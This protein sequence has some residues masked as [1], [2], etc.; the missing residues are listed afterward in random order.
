M[1][2]VAAGLF[3]GLS[4][5]APPGIRPTEDKV[6]QAVFNILGPAVGGCRFLDGFAGSG[7]LGIEALSRGAAFSAFIE[8]DTQ[9]VLAIRENL[10][11]LSPD[12]EAE[13]W[14]VL[15]LPAERGI[16]V[17][18]ESEDPFD[19]VLLDPPYASIDGKKALN[20]L[21]RHAILAPAGIVV[22]EHD[23][24][25]EQPTI[26]GPL[27]QWKQHRYGDTVLSLFRQA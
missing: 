20:A 12:V 3:K 18:A 2:R 8:S 10:E 1:S 11:R 26:I 9:A 23:R 25:T 17:L 7:A 21:S 6:R 24:R 5:K 19:F 14:R 16:A 22:L 4:L 15:H 27:K 13:S